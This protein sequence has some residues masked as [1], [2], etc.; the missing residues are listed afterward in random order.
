[1]MS[2]QSARI[3]KPL[4]GQ[5]PREVVVPDI[6]RP[7]TVPDKKLR[8]EQPKI[9]QPSLEMPKAVAIEVA[10]KK[11]SRAPPST[12]SAVKSVTVEKPETDKR[13]TVEGLSTNQIEQHMVL[14]PP[15]A[16]LS[17]MTRMNSATLNELLQSEEKSPNQILIDQQR[18]MAIMLFKYNFI[19][20]CTNHSN[21]SATLAEIEFYPVT[22]PYHPGDSAFQQAGHFYL[23][24]NPR[25]QDKNT[26]PRLV[27][28]LTAENR[29]AIL[30]RSILTPEGFIEGP[31][32][33]VEY[34]QSCN[35]DGALNL[36]LS[37]TEKNLVFDDTKIVYNG[38]R[39]GLNL[40]EETT[41]YGQYCMYVMK[42]FR[43]T[44][45]P[46]Q[47]K[48]YKHTLAV[49]ARLNGIPDTIINRD[50]KLPAEILGRWLLIFSR[51]DSC[52]LEM[53]MEGK[54][55]KLLD[56]QQQLLAYGFLSR[57]NK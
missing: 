51:G 29:C 21:K 23:R 55:R 38:P 25:H 19:I 39:V 5:N 47:I 48:T 28:Y 36:A 37:N 43:Y 26:T 30:V 10:A 52:Y 17:D 8:N 15:P 7:S 53:F 2:K 1:M 24:L 31:E 34:I 45:C 13:F 54:A 11:P 22:D 12:V 57:F 35:P 50:F 40:C 46:G 49:T 32:A 16:D 14:L 20:G 41:M 3:V 56:S 18:Q 33:V 44:F 4:T 42:P 9:F 6:F 27:L